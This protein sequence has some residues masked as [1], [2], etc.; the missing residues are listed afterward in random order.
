[1]KWKSFSADYDL[2]TLFFDFIHLWFVTSIIKALFYF[3]LHEIHLI[4]IQ[5]I[6]YTQKLK[7]SNSGKKNIIISII[8]IY[9]PLF[10]IL[11]IPPTHPNQN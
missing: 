9:P 10:H 1:M 2:W 4:A 6:F 7:A 3:Y 8:C 11:H 5:L